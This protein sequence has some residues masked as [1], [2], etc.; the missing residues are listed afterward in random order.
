MRCTKHYSKDLFIKNLDDIDWSDI[1]SC[2]N[3]DIAWGKIKSKLSSIL[4]KVAPYKEVRDKQ[5]KFLT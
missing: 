5:R 4:D 3:V 1:F 2:H